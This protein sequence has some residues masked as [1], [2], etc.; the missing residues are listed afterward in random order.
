MKVAVQPYV[1]GG[2]VLLGTRVPLSTRIAV[3]ELAARERRSMS[4]V[5]NEAVLA[6]LAKH[7]VR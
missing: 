6:H 2:R 7:S 5:V 4:S 1:T 3:E